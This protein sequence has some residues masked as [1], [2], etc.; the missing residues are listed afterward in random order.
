VTKFTR[1]SI[2]TIK[3]FSVY[4]KSAANSGAVHTEHDAMGVE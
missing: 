3:H 2:G 4:H 1:H